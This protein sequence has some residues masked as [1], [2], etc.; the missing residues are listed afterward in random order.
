MTVISFTFTCPKT[1]S[2]QTN[3]QNKYMLSMTYVFLP[4]E[5]SILLSKFEG[6]N[7]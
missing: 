2:K 6:I 3:K 7:N 5:G 4:Y 1:T